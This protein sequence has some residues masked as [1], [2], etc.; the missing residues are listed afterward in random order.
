MLVSEVISIPAKRI[1]PLQV[2][3]GPYHAYAYADGSCD[4]PTFANMSQN[5][6]QLFYVN[7]FDNEDWSH[8]VVP[9]NVFHRVGDLNFDF[10]IISNLKQTKIEF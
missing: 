2:L 7:F 3:N 9:E 4:G 8:I 1:T 10:C 6:T 5:L